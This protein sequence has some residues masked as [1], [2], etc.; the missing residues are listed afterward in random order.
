MKKDIKLEGKNGII[1]KAIILMDHKI[2]A[3]PKFMTQTIKYYK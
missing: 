1:I 3:T 2:K